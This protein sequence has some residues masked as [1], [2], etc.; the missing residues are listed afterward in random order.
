MVDRTIWN[1]VSIFD[2]GTR[3]FVEDKV[4]PG[5]H[6][7]VKG[8]LRSNRLER[9]GETVYTTDLAVDGFQRQ[10]KKA[11]PSAEPPRNENVGA[12]SGCLDIS[13]VKGGIG[14]SCQRTTKLARPAAEWATLLP[15]RLSCQRATNEFI[16]GGEGASIYRVAES[17]PITSSA[18]CG[19]PL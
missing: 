15:N 7:R 1:E 13:R 4:Q 19:G 8:T 16:R 10:A 2:R 12:A 11:A 18:R 17:W 9:D 3:G 14:L 5:D 6:V